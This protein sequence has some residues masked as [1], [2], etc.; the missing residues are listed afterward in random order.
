MGGPLV[1]QLASLDVE[2]ALL[3][4]DGTLLS[5]QPAFVDRAVSTE[6]GVGFDRRT[7]WHYVLPAEVQRRKGGAA[8]LSQQLSD[9]GLSAAVLSESDTRVYRFVQTPLGTSRA[10]RV[11]PAPAA[12]PAQHAR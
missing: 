8:A 12:S 1:D 11:P 7:A 6:H 3:A 5:T 2:V 4:E 10:P 9:L